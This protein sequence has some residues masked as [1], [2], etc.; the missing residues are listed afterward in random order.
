MLKAKLN[1]FVAFVEQKI[2][3]SGIAYTKFTVYA[4][5]GTKNQNGEWDSIPCFITAFD[6]C[7]G[8][9]YVQSKSFVQVVGQARPISYNKKTESG[10]VL[11]SAL[12]IIAESILPDTPGS[13][14]K[15]NIAPSTP[16]VPQYTPPPPPEYTDDSDV[17]F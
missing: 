9:E 7:T 17:P 14:G 12:E 16:P 2:A 4:S 8:I 15:P 13:K 6:K 10:T 3:K 5:P 11:T 1:G